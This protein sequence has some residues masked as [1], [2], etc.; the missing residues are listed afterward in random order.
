[1]SKKRD[2][3]PGE[4]TLPQVGAVLRYL[5]VD[6]EFRLIPDPHTALWD[7]RMQ[8]HE[9][10]TAMLRAARDLLHHV[11][12]N[13]QDCPGCEMESSID[14]ELQDEDEEHPLI[15]WQRVN[16]EQVGGKGA[17]QK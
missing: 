17:D 15:D 5:G 2:F 4:L 7:R 13:G 6:Y 1:M 16:Q 3:D 8:E 14:T 11:S 10:R 12:H 9:R